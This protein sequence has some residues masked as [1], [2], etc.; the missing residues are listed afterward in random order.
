MLVYQRV[1]IIHQWLLIML[2]YWITKKATELF[3][4]MIHSNFI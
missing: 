4:M 1:M 3:F 2:T